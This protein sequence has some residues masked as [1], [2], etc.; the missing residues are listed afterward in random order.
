MEPAVRERLHEAVLAEL[1]SKGRDGVGLAEV[2]RSAEVGEEEFAAEYADL[3]AL[4]DAAYERLT[5]QLDAA[6]Q[7]GCATGGD[8]FGASRPEWPQR[9]RAALEALLAELAANPAAAQALTT[10]YPSLGPAQQ[11]RYQAFV[12]SFARALRVRREMG[13]LVD[14]LPGEVDLLAVGA[15]E[16]IVA[17][18]IASGRTEELPAMVPSILFSVLA[19]YLG[20]AEAIAEMEKAGRG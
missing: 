14:G 3:D 15:A 20:P 4:I 12:E 2:L 11:A 6:V 16:A 19:P 10:A 1:G 17:E 5:I 8:W 13:G 9:V 18:E 7:V